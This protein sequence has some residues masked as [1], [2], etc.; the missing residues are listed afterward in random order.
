MSGKVGGSASLPRCGQMGRQAGRD[1]ALAPPGTYA[2]NWASDSGIEVS[3]LD[4]S[5]GIGPGAGPAFLGP[6]DSFEK[7]KTRIGELSVS[8]KKL[9][10]SLRKAC[11]SSECDL[12][13]C[14]FLNP[15][16]SLQ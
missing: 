2:R 7:K 15:S 14:Y 12:H 10:P 8:I 4:L 1:G 5:P 9:D 3:R 11:L 16:V 13:R 6:S